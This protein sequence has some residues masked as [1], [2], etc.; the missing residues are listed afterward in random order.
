ME[1][2][3]KTIS[4]Y[5]DKM[6][7]GITHTSAQPGTMDFF[8]NTE[9][10]RYFIESH[11]PEMA[12]FDNFS[13]KKVLEV[14][15]GLGCDLL[16]YAR[17]GAIVT[18]IDASENSLELAKKRFELYKMKGEFYRQDAEDLSFDECSFDLVY[19]FGVLHHTPGTQKSIDEIHRVLKP[20]GRAI[21][22]LYHRNSIKYLYSILF[23][24]GICSLELL[25]KTPQKLLNKYTEAQQNSPLTKAYSTLEGKR[26]FK[27]FK[28][29]ETFVRYLYR[30]RTEGYREGDF[31]PNILYSALPRGVFEKLSHVLGWHIIIKAEK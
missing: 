29:V 22:M 5:W 11:I 13:R 25:E 3:K 7:C 18:G 6:P 28:N 27:S 21:V 14:G 31:K 1:N 10:R 20:G 9:K 2:M 16:Q 4:R 24:K 30:F 23:I 26:M 8:E 17:S 19:S 15:C 12:E